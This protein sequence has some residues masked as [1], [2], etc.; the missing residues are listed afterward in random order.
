M[1]EESADLAFCL[2]GGDWSH[3]LVVLLEYLS[4]HGFALT[5]SS[6]LLRVLLVRIGSHAETMPVWIIINLLKAQCVKFMHGAQPWL[7]WQLP[8]P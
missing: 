1:S 6:L 7:P 5:M 3:L 2:H 4:I 8:W